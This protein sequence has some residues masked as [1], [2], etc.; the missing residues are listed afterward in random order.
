MVGIYQWVYTLGFVLC[1]WYAPIANNVVLA[2]I[3][4]L[5]L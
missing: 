5:V 4:A 1:I 3:I 2:N